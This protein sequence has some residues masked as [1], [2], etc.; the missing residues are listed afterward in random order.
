M[1]RAFGQTLQRQGC[2]GMYL[3]Y[4]Q[5]PLADVEYEILRE[6]AC[7]EAVLRRDRRYLLQPR[8][9]GL[10]FEELLDYGG[11]YSRL[12]RRPEDEITEPP[13]RVLPIELKE[14]EIASASIIISDELDQAKADGEMR[15]AILT[16][17]FA[18]FCVE[19]EIVVHFNDRVLSSEEAEISDERALVMAMQPRESPLEAPRAMSAHWF[20]YRLEPD[21]LREGENV[22]SVEVVRMERSAG[23]AR[24]LNGIEIQT[25]YRNLE[26]PAGLEVARI[27]A[28]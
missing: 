2:Q 7:P 9:A 19:D 25:R 26:R 5:W 16:I 23:F 4:L 10:V 27:A 12:P 14:G 13:N 20:R 22:V 15:Q 18:F 1:Y 6:V 3:G 28:Q 11:G 21:L 24:L 8:E 17:R